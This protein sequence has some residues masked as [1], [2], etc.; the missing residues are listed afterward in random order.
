MAAKEKRNSPTRRTVKAPPTIPIPKF[1]SKLANWIKDYHA[2]LANYKQAITSATGKSDAAA[3]SYN[4]L[5]AQRAALQSLRSLLAAN[6]GM[7]AAAKDQPDIPVPPKPP[8]PKP[9]IYGHDLVKPPCSSAQKK[10]EK[11]RCSTCYARESQ[12]RDDLAT[13][14]DD[15]HQRN[16][17]HEAG[18]TAWKQDR[19]QYI[20]DLNTYT[21][22]IGAYYHARTTSKPA[23]AKM[24]KLMLA[25][26]VAMYKSL[27]L[28]YA[29][30]ERRAINLNA[31]AKEINREQAIWLDDMDALQIRLAKFLMSLKCGPCKKVGELLDEC[32]LLWA[33][34]VL[35]MVFPESVQI[36]FLP[37]PRPPGAP[38]EIKT[39]A[40]YAITGVVADQFVNPLEGVEVTLTGDSGSVVR[41]T[42]DANGEYSFDVSPGTY[43]L[44]IDRPFFDYLE[45][46]IMV[47]EKAMVEA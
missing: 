38:V 9:N 12:A 5:V 25:K 31:E 37:P 14:M 2:S 20:N 23:S 41:Q 40:S 22:G 29:D 34:F 19:D 4:A 11:K 18:V 1:A 6:Q 8:K 33:N 17:D 30:L 26:L 42:A 10:I 15:I 36:D 45:D 24:L 27:Q 32:R 47:T 13:T 43:K 28:Q 16:S 44:T 7:K 21:T 46:T 35:G 39:K 3:P